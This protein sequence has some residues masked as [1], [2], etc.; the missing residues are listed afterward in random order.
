[1]AGVVVRLSRAVT[2]L[3]GRLIRGIGFSPEGPMTRY[4]DLGDFEA[5]RRRDDETWRRG[6]DEEGPPR[7]R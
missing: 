5:K 1:M 7:S 3:P 4:S 6:V 2:Q